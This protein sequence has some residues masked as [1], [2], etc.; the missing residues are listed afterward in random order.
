MYRD[1]N[2]SEKYLW[3]EKWLYKQQEKRD[4]NISFELLENEVQ[5]VKYLQQEKKVQYQ[6][7][8]LATTVATTGQCFKATDLL[9]TETSKTAFLCIETSKTALLCPETF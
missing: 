1:L 9:C 2:C 3:K 4:K 7:W 5:N 8:A 6:S